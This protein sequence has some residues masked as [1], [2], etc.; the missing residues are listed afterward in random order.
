VLD[1][2]CGTGALLEATARRW[3]VCV[4]VDSSLRRLVLARQ[5]LKQAGVKARLVCAN[6]DALPFMDGVFDRVIAEW[7]L[8][9]APSQGRSL[10]EWNRML[11]QQGRL[12]I[13]TPNRWSVGPDPH[14]GV[15]ALSWLPQPLLEVWAKRHGLTVPQRALVGARRLR[16]LLEETGFAQ[17]RLGKQL[18][19]EPE[20]ETPV[21]RKRPL[22]NGRKTLQDIALIRELAKRI[23]PTLLA[24]AGRTHRGRTRPAFDRYVARLAL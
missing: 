22:A 6:I 21:R 8:E 23:T 3:P 16:R 15:P 10:R 2:G 24:A 13:T 5:R 9:V 1:V 19:D 17:V 12:W 18:A 7:I 14:L 11:S 4:G 20:H